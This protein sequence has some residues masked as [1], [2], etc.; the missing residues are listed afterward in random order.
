MKKLVYILACGLLFAAC[1]KFAAPES[2]IEGIQAMTIY[3]SL[4]D[5]FVKVSISDDGGIA[6]WQSGDQ[7][8]LYDGSDFVTFTLSD[9]A[10][11]AFTGPSGDYT[12]LAVYPAAMANSVNID[13]ELLLT[14]PDQ[15]N[16]SSACTNAPMIAVS[17]SNAYT[18]YPVG[19]LFKFTF[20]NIPAG[21]TK[22]HFSS[23]GQKISGSFNVGKPTPGTSVLPRQ[24]ATSDSE[25]AVSINLSA[26]HASTMS[27]YLPVPIFDDHFAVSLSGDDGI[28]FAELNSSIDVTRCQMRRYKSQDCAD[29][30]PAK[31]YLI[32]G[33]LDNGWSFSDDHVL[34]KGANGVYSG[35]ETISGGEWDGFKMYMGNDWSATWLSI[36]EENSTHDH[37]IPFGGEAYKAAH[38]VGD[39]Q[40]YLHNYGYENGT[41][42][43]TLDLF[44]K[45]MTLTPD[46]WLPRYFLSGAALTSGW[47]WP[48]HA[49][50]QYVLQRQSAGVYTCSAYLYLD[51]D[52][53]GLK[54]YGQPGWGPIVYSADLSSGNEFR[55]LVKDDEQF[56][57]YRYGYT[58]GNYEIKVDFNQMRVFFTAE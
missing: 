33:C 42:A 12:G 34:T 37:L 19:G 13:G 17:T 2:S 31:I 57:P 9:A 24:N 18:F 20:S 49:D 56:Y 45:T 44:N 4:P 50:E 15:Y 40:I 5:E 26:G 43:I 10:T 53:R 3:A 27:F 25:K 28:P 30:L 8:A 1:G 21:V 23:D 58:S 48:D 51:H 22:L 46:P 7:I 41:Y 36:D 16:W 38:G 11:G 6:S 14:L 29:A 52:N 47:G 55:I 32:G 35:L 54:I 39:T